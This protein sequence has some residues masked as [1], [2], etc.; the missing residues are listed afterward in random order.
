M[1]GGSSISGGAEHGRGRG[2]K[3]P[4]AGDGEI[5]KAARATGEEPSDLSGATPTP[6]AKG[7]AKAKGKAVPGMQGLQRAVLPLTRYW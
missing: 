5:P 2:G 3:R 4:A 1:E 7:K 6:T